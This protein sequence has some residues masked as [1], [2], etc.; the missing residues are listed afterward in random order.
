MIYFDNSATTPV[1]PEV[2]DAMLPFFKEEYG[3]PS[4]K[5]YTLAENA[6]K[7]VEEARFHIAELL[8][9]D[10]DEVVFT[11]GATE[12]N[13]MV[14]KG[15]L[16]TR[17]GVRIIT[18]KTE[19]PS[20]LDTA[21]YLESHGVKV[22]YLDV[23]TYGFCDVDQLDTL[24]ESDHHLKTLVSVV[25][26]NN[27][28]GTLNDLSTISSI[29]AKHGVSLH[30]DATQVAGKV[31]ID[32]SS[33]VITFLSLSSHKI[34]GPKGIGACI[35]KKDALGIRTKL[36]PLLHGGGQEFGYRSGTLNVHNIVGFGKAAEIAKRD[37]RSTMKHLAELEQYLL[38]KL[39]EKLS[40]ILHL[41]SRAA[42]KIP[43][44]VNIR[45][46]GVNNELLVKKLADH[47]AIS[48]GSA[49]SSSKP[50]HV[51]QSIGLTL[52]QVRSSVRISLSRF[53]TRDEI[54]LFIDTLT[55]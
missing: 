11:S 13:N 38:Q 49:C 50:S 27:E 8:K 21:Q 51:L 44:I 55:R 54:D 28:I 31:E 24:L 2:F 6:K 26:G 17:S 15:Y 48:T 41:N 19:H 12:S 40:G 47:F 14:L 23:D 9:C 46:E 4:S 34:H 36:T 25:W 52:D 35:I 18:T 33:Q 29:C 16:D 7:A 20:V 5:Y 10:P 32:L 42:T 37:L 39:H 43:G 1:H 53:N 45:F 30:T 3:N 22:H